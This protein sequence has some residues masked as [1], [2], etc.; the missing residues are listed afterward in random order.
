[1]TRRIVA[2]AVAVPVLV[3]S[4]GNTQSQWEQQ[5]R[6]IPDSVRVRATIEKLSAQ[7]H[8]AGTPASKQ[9]AEWL[10]GQLRGF[11]LDAT[12]ETFEA[13]LPVPEIRV[14]E[15]TAPSKFT[16]K[17]SE[18]RVDADPFTGN[19]DIVPPYNAYSGDGDVTA[20]LVYANYGLPADYDTLKANG[21]DV[22]GKIVIVRYGGSFRGVKPRVAYEH[23]AVGCIIYSD[24]RDDGYFQGDSFPK[25]PFRPADGVQRG[26]V[27]DLGVQPGDPL[28]PGWAS[29]P[30]S[31]RL[32]VAEAK[33]IQQIPVLP[34]SYAD[35]TPLLSAL[36]GPVA[37]LAW[38]GALPLTYHLGPGGATVHLKVKMNNATR[39]LYNVI[40][41]IPGAEFPDEWILF[42]NHHDAWV[43][44][45]SDPLSGVAPLLETARAMAELSRQGWRPK[46]T[47]MFAFWDGEEFGLVGS[48]E[49]MEKH[50]DELNRKLAVYINSDSSGKGTFS[51]GGS[52][53]LDA[54]IKDTA[55]AVKD[56]VNG[57]SLL[58]TYL[59]KTAANAPNDKPAE[60]H[61]SPLGSGS[62]FTPF[63][64]HLG[65]AS[66]SL[67]F[68]SEAGGGVYHSAYDD[69]F[70]YSRFE[71][72]DFI[73]GRTLAQLNSTVALRLCD[74][75]LLPFAFT[76]LPAA[77][78]TY[79][80][81]IEKLGKVDL[82]AVRK[83]NAH[84]E[85]VAE[86]FTKAA[87]RS[88]ANAQTASPEKRAAIDRIL[89]GTERDLTLDP[90]LPGRPWYR[91]RIYAPGRY[92]GYAVKTLPGIREA[93]E[94]KKSGEAAEQA[95]Q[96]AQVLD[97]LAAHL[98]AAAKLLRAL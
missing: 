15:M 56:P 48:T 64:Q 54:F 4:A 49:W 16:A 97:T 86:D 53:S 88:A 33:T 17:L 10:L 59:A 37:P 60:F 29:E 3:F 41:K 38:R 51:A 44:G 94:A 83:S 57:K 80:T 6:A 92:T 85:Q 5:A 40:A 23:G 31:K 67:G 34:I 7:P 27:L 35:A 13:L 69:F 55:S 50:A 66:L 9:T 24:P 32:S 82:A 39:P 63:L 84:L 12:I 47:L 90:G 58:D 11:G 95:K 93:V 30:G 98:E 79:L 18:P 14:L 28:S 42:G 75:P 43:A 72:S 68:D 22:Q 52:D 71:D 36:D 61:L 81:E 1:M 26:S 45:A 65:I 20:P 77:M 2:L 89:I 91:H 96:L 70:W 78:N 87:A 76:R 8:L 19:P 73:Y 74:T 25:G 21:I 62:D 46:R